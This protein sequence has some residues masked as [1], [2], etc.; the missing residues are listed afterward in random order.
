M[1]HARLRAVI[2]LCAAARNRADNLFLSEGLTAATLEA[3]ARH[4]SLMLAMESAWE[5]AFRRHRESVGGA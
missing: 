4:E 1:D 2:A 5:R 3:Q